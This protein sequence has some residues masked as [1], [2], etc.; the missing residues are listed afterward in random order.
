MRRRPALSAAL[1]ALAVAVT[2]PASAEPVPDPIPHQATY[3]MSL[4]RTQPGTGVNGVDGDMVYRLTDTCDGWAVESRTELTISG[5]TSLHTRYSYLAWEA[6]DG[7]RFTFRTHNQRNGRTVEAYE[8]EAERTDDG[9]LEAVFRSDGEVIRRLDLPADTL[10]PMAHAIALLRRAQ[11]GERFFN[12]PL[13]DGSTPE[14]RYQVGIGIG[15]RLAADL[16][17]DLDSPLLALP[18]WPINLAFFLDDKQNSVPR[19]EMTMRYHLNGV[20]QRLIQSYPE[21]TLK[22]TLSDLAPSPAPDC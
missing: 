16:P 21:F 11:D 9:R 2:A 4:L 14:N 1:L 22:G 8:G 7:S 17:G 12:A 13:F 20:S 3:R 10:L 19:F 15:G 5:T 18:S 6:R